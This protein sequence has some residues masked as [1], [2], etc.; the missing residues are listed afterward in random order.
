[1][2]LTAA[3]LV[4]AAGALEADSGPADDVSLAR[5]P[6]R[7]TSTRPPDPTTTT[8]SAPS[9]TTTTEALGLAAV[10]PVATTT[11]VERPAPAEVVEAPTGAHAGALASIRACESGGDYGAV[12]P[13]GKYRGAYQFD[14]AT[15][16]GVGGTG[17]PAAASPAEQDLRAE[18][19]YE[20]RGAAPWPVCGR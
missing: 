11:T 7:T 5:A 3:L 6:A 2:A 13:S 19:L 14:R 20:Q 9:T 12:N 1:M 10:A 15:W 8:T 16:A 18:L 17:D 4:V